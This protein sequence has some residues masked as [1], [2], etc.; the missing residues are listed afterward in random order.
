MRTLLVSC[1]VLAA[2]AV[3]CGKRIPKPPAGVP[4][5]AMYAGTPERGHFIHFEGHTQL[6][7]NVKIYDART[8]AVVHAS[9]FRVIGLARSEVL[10]EELVAWDGEF[11][12]LK[13]GTRLVPWKK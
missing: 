12:H 3:G 1:L 11:I 8:G 4:A 10:P 9:E 7:W 5:A 6:G 13:D 2:L